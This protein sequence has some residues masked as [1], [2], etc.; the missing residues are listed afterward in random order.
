MIDV[1]NFFFVLNMKHQIDD[2]ASPKLEF[3]KD[4][5]TQAV[6]F[7]EASLMRLKGYAD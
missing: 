5:L 2:D 3:S 7:A 4:Q 6:S 1:N